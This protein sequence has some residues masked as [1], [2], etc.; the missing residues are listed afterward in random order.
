MLNSLQTLGERETLFARQDSNNIFNTF[1]HAK[2]VGDSAGDSPHMLLTRRTD[3]TWRERL[4]SS[5][6]SIFR[7][8]Q[9]FTVGLIV[10]VLAGA[11]V[12]VLA[13]VTGVVHLVEQPPC[14]DERTEERHVVESGKHV[15]EQVADQLS[16]LMAP[17]VALGGKPRIVPTGHASFFPTLKNTN[18]PDSA[19]G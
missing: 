15:A 8:A 3:S 17:N 7:R 1:F 14:A 16:I 10:R 18:S 13:G 19:A 5:G 4:P 2:E 9:R 11:I 6:A 12:R